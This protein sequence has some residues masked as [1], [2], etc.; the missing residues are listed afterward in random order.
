MAVELSSQ[1]C[2]QAEVR[3]SGPPLVLL[4]GLFASGSNLR[5]VANE[6]ANTYTV[7]SIDL[8]LHGKSK[9]VRANS[10]EAMARHVM[11]YI[12]DNS[13]FMPV[14]V[15]H[16]LGGKVAMSA[17]L[18]GLQCKALVVLDIAPVAYTASHQ[19]AFGAIGRVAKSALI[20]RQ[21]VRDCMAETLSD[22]MTIDFLSTQLHKSDA[23]HFQWKFDWLALQDNYAA[24]LAAPVADDSNETP[25]LFIAGEHSNYIAAEGRVAI[26]SFFSNSRIVTLK[27]AGHWPHAQKFEE[28]M[29]MLQYFLRSFRSEA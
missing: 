9:L 5:A 28:L 7:H 21:A 2:L 27:G 14:V 1:N 23:G 13:I 17:V 6:L 18:A 19:T 3:G 4:H 22:N 24:F 29:G 16:S 26:K 10:I 11:A 20:S 25:S 12:Q 8:P 15:G